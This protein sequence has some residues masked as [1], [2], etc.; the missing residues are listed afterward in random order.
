[1]LKFYLR[2]SISIALHIL[3]HEPLAQIL[4]I[5]DNTETVSWEIAL[6]LATLAPSLSSPTQM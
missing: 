4:Q 6:D 2:F 3:F 5:T 1:M